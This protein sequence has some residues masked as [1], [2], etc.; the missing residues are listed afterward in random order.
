MYGKGPRAII[1]NS[2]YSKPSIVILVSEKFDIKEA[3]SFWNI[4]ASGTYVAWISFSTLESSLDEVAQ[5]LNSEYVHTVLSVSAGTDI[6]FSSSKQELSKL[7]HIVEILQ[8]K[9]QIEFPQWHSMSYEDTIF[10][11]YDRPSAI[12]EQVIVVREGNSRF[13]FIPDMPKDYIAGEWTIVLR[14]NHS[15]LPYC[16]P[17]FI[18]SHISSEIVSRLTRAKGIILPKFRVIK[19]RYLGMQNMSTKPIEF[20]RPTT[21]QIINALFADGGFPYIEQSSTAKYH[22]SFINRC[23]ALTDTA[24]YLAT[25]PYRELFEALADNS[26]KN[27]TGWILDYPSKRRALHH[28]HLRDVLNETT[29]AETKSYFNTVSDELPTEAFQLLEK[30]LLERGFQLSCIACSYKSWYP[31]EHVGQ[32]FECSRCFQTQVYNA[33]PLWLYKLPEVVFQGFEDNMQVPLLALDY[34][35]RASKHSLN[36]YRTPMFIHIKKVVRRLTETLTSYVS[37]MASFI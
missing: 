16:S 2:Y 1:K 36:G 18:Q 32:T 10:Y 20:N 25:S 3:T 11:N 12:E 22:T 34:L 8:A 14:W 7:L 23:G 30:G 27:K 19:D 6:V 15:T 4:R 37:A 28:L 17:Q 33:N 29:P 31:A 35:R 26:N 5:W 9:K 24:Y 13:S 21:S